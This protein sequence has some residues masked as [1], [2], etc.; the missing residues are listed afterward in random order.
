MLQATLLWN[1]QALQ[2]KKSRV[3]IIFKYFLI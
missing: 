3:K 1:T 2:K